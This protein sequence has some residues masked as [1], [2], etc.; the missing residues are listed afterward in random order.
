VTTCS[1]AIYRSLPR[2]HQESL[3]S[4]AL[5]TLTSRACFRIGAK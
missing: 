3:T 5:L 4:D 2:S 1:S